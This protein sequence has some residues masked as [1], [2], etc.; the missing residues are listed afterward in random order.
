MKELKNKKW[1]KIAAK[2]K[3]KF[4]G[5]VGRMIARMDPKDLAGLHKSQ[6]SFIS[7]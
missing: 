5:S 7:N 3:T 1:L 4:T 2:V 6:K